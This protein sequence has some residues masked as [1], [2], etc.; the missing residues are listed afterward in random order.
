MKSRASVH[1]D[2]DEVR[3]EHNTLARPT[4]SL[5]GCI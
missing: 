4:H 1:V 3:D 2:V 5:R